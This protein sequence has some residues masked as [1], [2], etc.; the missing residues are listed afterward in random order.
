MFIRRGSGQQGY[1][2]ANYVKEIEPANVK[3][4]VIK[5]VMEEV[6]VNVKKKH[7]VKRRVKKGPVVRKTRSFA[8]S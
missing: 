6:P 3:K 7:M 2:P 1:V 4:K 8:S 5:K